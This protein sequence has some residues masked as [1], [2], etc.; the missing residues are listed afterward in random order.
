MINKSRKSEIAK[1]L[2]KWSIHFLLILIAIL[3]LSTLT[4]KQGS[5]EGINLFKIQSNPVPASPSPFPSPSPT[6]TSIPSPSPTPKPVPVISKPP[7]PSEK[8][9]KVAGSTYLV[10]SSEEWR[11]KLREKT[12][13]PKSDENT[14]IIQL[15][16]W[17]DKNQGFL[18]KWEAALED[19]RQ[20]QA[21]TPVDIPPP[22]PA[23]NNLQ[24]LH[25]T[26]NTIGDYTYTNCF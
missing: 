26:S 10:Y 3:L 17:L 18:A 6:P 14:E 8:A 20:Q 16:L 23:Q 13:V 5:F 7:T 19:Y 25:C 15:A 2:H 21:R 24:S 9:L 22:L 12:G 4:N 1:F 11:V